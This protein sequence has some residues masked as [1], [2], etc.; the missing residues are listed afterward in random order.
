MKSKFN[1]TSRWNSRV[2]FVWIVALKINLIFKYIARHQLLCTQYI[3]IASAELRIR[4]LYTTLAPFFSF[5]L[6]II[7]SQYYTQMAKF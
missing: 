6:S 5:Y 2:D 3:Y 7:C 4:I 1:H